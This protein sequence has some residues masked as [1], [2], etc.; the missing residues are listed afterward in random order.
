ME[1]AE[2]RYKEL[3]TQQA[4][5]QDLE[6]KVKELE[7]KNEELQS[8][9][10]SQKQEILTQKAQFKGAKTRD[11]QEEEILKLKKHFEEEIQSVNKKMEKVLG[12]EEK[13]LKEIE[14]QKGYNNELQEKI[15]AL[16]EQISQMDVKQNEKYVPKKFI[17]SFLINFITSNSP[18]QK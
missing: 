9:V 15:V 14:T 6:T 10:G 3:Q 16:I 18:T 8:V 11:E 12:K 17:T 2:N 4:N 5:T 13:R 7:S 1:D